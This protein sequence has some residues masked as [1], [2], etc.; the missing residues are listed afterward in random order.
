MSTAIANFSSGVAVYDTSMMNGAS[1]NTQAYSGNADISLNAAFMQYMKTSTALTTYLTDGS[2]VSF[3]GWFYPSGTQAVGATIFD[4]SFATTSISLFYG[5]SSTLSAFF[6]GSTVTSTY[7]VTPNTWHFFCYTLVCNAVA[8]GSATTPTTYYALQKLYIDVPTNLVSVNSAPYLAF[9]STGNYLGYGL[10]SA[11]AV[12]YTYFNGKLDDFRGYSRALSPSEISVLYNYNYGTNTFPPAKLA[13]SYTFGAPSTSSIPIVISGTFGS[14]ELTRSPAF[15]AGK[16]TVSAAAVSLGV[17]PSMTYYDTTVLPDVSYTYTLKAIAADASGAVV[18]TAP[19]FASSVQNGDFSAFASASSWVLPVSGASNW[20]SSSTAPAYSNWVLGA[21]D[22]FQATGEFNHAGAG[23]SAAGYGALVPS[24]VAYYHVMSVSP[25]VG[26]GSLAQTVALGASRGFLS[27]YAWN[28]YVAGQTATAYLT[29]V[30]GGTVLLNA[31]PLPWSAVMAKTEFFLPYKV[32]VAGSYPLTFTVTGTATGTAMAT[33]AVAL[34]NVKVALPTTVPS[35]STSIDP[36]GL[37]LYY[38]FPAD[39]STYATGVRGGASSLGGGASLGFTSPISPIDATGYLGLTGG[40][41]SFLTMDTWVC[42]SNNLVGGG[43]S[44]TGWFYASNWSVAN[45][46]VFSMGNAGSEGRV[47]MYLKNTGGSPGQVD[48]SINGVGGLDMLMGDLSL[49]AGTWY[50]FALTA[51]CTTLGNGG[52]GYYTV[53]L[54]DVVYR[55]AT[56]NWPLV[57]LGSFGTNT[58]GGVDAAAGLELGNLAGCIDDF[59]VYNRTI[60]PQEVASLWTLGYSKLNNYAGVV[61]TSGLQSYYSFDQGSLTTMAPAALG[62][63]QVVGYTPTSWTVGWSLANATT[64]NYSATTGGQAVAVNA[65]G[66]NPVTV[67]GLSTAGSTY[68][69]TVAGLYNNSANM[70]TGSVQLGVS[71]V[72]IP[73]VYVTNYTSTG[74]DVSWTPIAGDVSNCVYC[75]S[76]GVQVFPTLTPLGRCYFRL[77]DLSAGVPYS[78]S[79]MSLVSGALTVPQAPTGVN[80][81][82]S[83]STATVS[84]TGV[85]GAAIY[86][87]TS[88]PGG[89]TGTSTG[90]PITVTGLVAGFYLFVVTAGNA[91]GTSTYSA[92]SSSVALAPLAPTGVSASVSVNVATISFTPSVGATSYTA[93]SNTGGFTGT[94]TGSPITV[95]GLALGTY[96]FTVTATGTSGT[97][98]ASAASGSVTVTVPAAPTGVGAMI[99]FSTATVSFIPSTGATSYTATSTPSGLTGTGTASPITVSGLSPGTYTFTVTATGVLGTSV[100]STASNAVAVTAPSAPT[101]VSATI[102]ESAATVSFTASTGATSYTATSSPG[103]IMGTATSS[104][105]TVTGLALGTSYT[106]TVTASNAGGTSPSS[107]PA[108]NQVTAPDGSTSALAVSSAAYLTANGKTTNGVYWINLP[109]AGATQIYCILDPAVDGGGWMMAMKATQGTTFPYSSSYWTTVNVLNNTDN[110]RNDADAKFNSMNYY[111]ATDMMALWPDVPYNYGSGTGGTMTLSSYSW[112]WLRRSTLGSKT[113]INYFSTTAANTAFD[114]TPRTGKERGTAF[115]DQAGNQFYGVN[116]TL[117]GNEEVRWGFAWNNETDWGSNDVRGGIGLGANTNYSAGDSISCCQVQTGFNRKARL[118]MYVRNITQL[119]ENP[120]PALTISSNGSYAYI[121]KF[122]GNGVFT[123]SSTK[124][125]QVLI[126]GGG[127]GGAIGAYVSGLY[128]GGGGGGGGGGVGVGSIT[129]SPGVIYNIT[130]GSGGTGANSSLTTGPASGGNSSII[131]GSVN[132]T[133]YGGGGGGYSGGGSAAANAGSGGSGGGVFAQS[134]AGGSATRG[135]GTLTYYGNTGGSSSTYGYGAGGGGATGLSGGTTAGGGTGGAGY[136]WS[137]TGLVYGSGG[138]GGGSDGWSG[139]RGGGAGG[140]NAGSGGTK[141]NA[142]SAINGYG[143]GGG[144]GGP[145]S[146]Y[147]NSTEIFRGGN[148]GRGAVIIAFN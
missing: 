82:A 25:V 67:T 81:S 145:D 99:V 125:A 45:Q 111:V 30:L 61:D 84:F 146:T 72:L 75:A 7:V 77:S 3:T 98:A 26:S 29:V 112:C 39:A 109:T 57:G 128:G 80:V 62:G 116:Y 92:P 100:P 59:R 9:T 87:A 56:G 129:F 104:P 78:V 136:T 93:T 13:L 31:Y 21:G 28:P 40:A 118:E 8:V 76:G 88:F 74:F 44:I 33:A 79:A 126:V 69:L 144:G 89:Y 68:A 12:P 36:S 90:S 132:E 22:H 41:T 47:S 63:L 135:S 24:N 96:T 119:I 27:F 133:A 124:T 10:G 101:G 86:T 141:Y 35:S 43:F 38:P 137:L 6:N 17:D 46:T 50:F 106:F 94:S 23:I 95:S 97:S 42:P 15:A 110:T 2:G 130:V 65:T 134:G 117:R 114:N 55:T 60:S 52:G 58:L 11:G 70:T 66:S 20:L 19:M 139:V 71:P 123:V 148:G 115:S 138:G 53:Y 142:T 51:Q 107:T 143:G 108:S 32:P 73:K 131:G 147:A 16:V 37:S 121:Y 48:V 102:T 103:G 54:N 122:N 1:L 120:L 4:I 85:A 113:L 91:V 5:T 49:N 34:A 127:G 14:V 140:T 64:Y 105:I 83:G 18:T